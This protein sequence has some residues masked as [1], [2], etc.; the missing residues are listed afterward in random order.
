MSV[1]LVL[2]TMVVLAPACPAVPVF[3]TPVVYSDDPEL[4]EVAENCKICPAFDESDW[5]NIYVSPS[6][7]VSFTGSPL[8]SMM[9]FDDT[10]VTAYVIVAMLE[11]WVLC[12]DYILNHQ[13]RVHRIMSRI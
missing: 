7:K 10:I 4:S 3:V 9:N 13:E 1:V 2:V 12:Q 5:S 6:L 8:P 11:C